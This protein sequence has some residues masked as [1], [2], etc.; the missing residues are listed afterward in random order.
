MKIELFLGLVATV[1]GEFVSGFDNT[2]FPVLVNGTEFFIYSSN[3]PVDYN[4]IYIKDTCSPS[5]PSTC[6]YMGD[7]YCCGQWNIDSWYE[8]D[9][10]QRFWE[11][12]FNNDWYGTSYFNSYS[13]YHCELNPEF[14]D[15]FYEND[16]YYK[17]DSR[18]M[19][20]E[21]EDYQLARHYK[22]EE[23][24]PED[25]LACREWGREYCCATY[26][27]PDDVPEYYRETYGDLQ[28][29]S[30]F[31]IKTGCELHPSYYNFT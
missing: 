17:Y 9:L 23:C 3:F 14:Y 28:T 11:A 30:L 18:Y 21:C 4:W 12:A 6:A 16:T 26:H 1:T 7:N 24:D 15:S 10:K 22:F 31:A 5:D 29:N 25:R 19:W 27:I 8:S 13:G 20:F 2:T